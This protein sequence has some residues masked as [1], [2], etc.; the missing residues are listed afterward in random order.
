MALMDKYG[1]EKGRERG[2]EGGREGGGDK[3]KGETQT[4]GVGCPRVTMDAKG[5]TM[6][7]IHTHSRVTLLSTYYECAF[8]FA[9]LYTCIIIITIIIISFMMYNR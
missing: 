5:F 4:G 8:N 1:G 7:D 2:R 9:L 6:K 3:G